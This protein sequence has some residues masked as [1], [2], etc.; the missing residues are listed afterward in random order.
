MST[1]DT[2]GRVENHTGRQSGVSGTTDRVGGRSSVTTR[3]SPFANL[4]GS[5]GPAHGAAGSDDHVGS[6]RVGLLRRWRRRVRRRRRGRFRR[7]RRGRGRVRRR[8]G[9]R[10][11]GRQVRGRRRC[12]SR[13]RCRRRGGRPARCHTSAAAARATAG[14]RTR[15]AAGPAAAGPTGS[16]GRTGVGS[17]LAGLAVGADG[18]AGRRVEQSRR[19]LGRE[20]G[21]ERLGR[22]RIVGGHGPTGEGDR[23]DADHQG[24]RD[25]RHQP[26]AGRPTHPVA[27]VR[28]R[29]GRRL[30]SSRG[31]A[32]GGDERDSRDRD[33][34]RD[35]CGL[36]TRLAA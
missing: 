4:R 28:G 32:G 35:R 33:R 23:P 36:R 18:R 27:C 25:G 24:D 6:D 19:R 34:H 11:R 10:G 13:G 30:R 22:R 21:R 2:P 29:R 5:R 7:R 3:V 16:I 17:G 9:G 31:R 20:F 1:H 12:R 26:D 8:R 14:A 15:S